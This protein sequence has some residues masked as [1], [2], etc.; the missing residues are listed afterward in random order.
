MF[1]ET[2][3]I[4][5]VLDQRFERLEELGHIADQIEIVA[6]QIVRALR[7]PALPEHGSVDDAL[8]LVAKLAYTRASDSGSPRDILAGLLGHAF[9]LACDHAEAEGATY[10]QM[11]KAAGVAPSNLHAFRNR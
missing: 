8:K 5:T 4:D 2:D 1:T 6:A 3:E 10:A 11:A 9:R 7:P